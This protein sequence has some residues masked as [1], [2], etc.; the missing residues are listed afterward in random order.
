S[1]PFDSV[2]KWIEKI[3]HEHGY[4]KTDVES[5][6][7]NALKLAEEAGDTPK[8]EAAELLLLS[9]L[10]EDEFGQLILARELFKGKLFEKNIP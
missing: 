7:I 1:L 5:T 3:S 9:G 6:V 4:T 8:V 2:E 10:T